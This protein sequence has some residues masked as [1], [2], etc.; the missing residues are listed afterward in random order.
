MTTSERIKR[1]RPRQLE[2]K[3]PEPPVVSTLHLPYRIE[4]IFCAFDY[5]TG[6]TGLRKEIEESLEL[7]LMFTMVAFTDLP[8]VGR[9]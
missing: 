9:R 7:W 3:P 8:A 2:A 4:P 6:E 5:V 1:E